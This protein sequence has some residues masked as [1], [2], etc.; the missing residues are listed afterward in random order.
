MQAFW[1][2][3]GVSVF[4]LAERIHNWDR[5]RQRY[6]AELDREM[7]AAMVIHHCGIKSAMQQAQEWLE[8]SDETAEAV[9]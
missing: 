7:T 8:G 1:K 4:T 5:Y 2:G 3:Q 9:T 6:P